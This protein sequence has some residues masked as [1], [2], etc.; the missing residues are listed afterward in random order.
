MSQ[1]VYPNIDP[2]SVS[3]TQLSIYLNNFKSAFLSGLLGTTRPSE[4]TQGGFWVDASDIA[5]NNLSFKVFDGSNDI[6]IFTVNT[7]D[8]TVTFNGVSSGGGGGGSG[9]TTPIGIIGEIVQ[10]P[11]METPINFLLCNGDAI[12]RTTYSDLFEKIGIEYGSGDGVTTFNL[13]D[14]RGYFLRSYSDDN[15]TDKDGPREVGSTQTDSFKSH[16]H[17]I[18]S[19]SG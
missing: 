2:E 9:N 17:K 19:G 1:N 18:A 8:D 11:Y 12:S 14:Y 5:N 10:L 15:T 13:P 16:S 4:I 7:N 3:G 6:V